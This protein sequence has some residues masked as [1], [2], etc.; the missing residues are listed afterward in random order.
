MYCARCHFNLQGL[1]THVCPECGHAFD[2]S[3]PATYLEKPPGAIARWW[4]RAK[5]VLVT[6]V[7][8]A[9][10]FT[11]TAVIMAARKTMRAEE[12]L[13]ATRVVCDLIAEHVENSPTHAWPTSW[14]DLE[15]LPPRQSIFRWPEDTEKFKAIVIVD[16][17][18]TTQQVLKQSPRTCTAVTLTPGPDF[19]G[20]P[21]M[22]LSVLFE[23]LQS[24][25]PAP[26]MPSSTPP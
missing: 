22:E 6:L 11:V 7:V 25:V 2:P 3:E 10:A 16:F 4:S 21:H 9:C 24:L 14:A 20:S 12:R 18:Q 13:Q 23:R 1:H 5:P 8:L 26:T 15:K 17:T 19:S